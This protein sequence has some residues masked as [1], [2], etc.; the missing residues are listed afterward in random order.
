MSRQNTQTYKTRNWPTYN[1]AI[2]RRG[3]LTIGFDPEMTRE[4]D[5]TG[6]RGRQPVDSDPAT[7]TCL[8]MKALFG[9]A[10]GQTKGFVES[11]LRLIGLNWTVPDDAHSTQ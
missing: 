4:A 9:L 7:Q 2:K 3:A 10:L 5:P 8:T 11:M 1:V 6:K